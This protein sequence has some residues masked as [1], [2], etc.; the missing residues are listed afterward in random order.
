MPSKTKKVEMAM[1]KLPS[2]PKELIDH[3]V[4]GPMTGEAVNA[5]SLAFKRA[6]IERAMGAELSHHLGYSSGEDKPDATTNYRNGATGKTVLTDNGALR[7]EVPRDREGSFAP[8]LIPKHERHFTGF[9]D[10]IIAM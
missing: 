6:L 2:I 7:I 4:K 3:F 1:A 5:A 8:L 9:D 10:K